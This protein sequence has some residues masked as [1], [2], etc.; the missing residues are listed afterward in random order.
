VARAF[1]AYEL[2]A[3]KKFTLEQIFASIKKETN[4][5]YKLIILLRA[6]LTLCAMNIGKMTFKHGHF[7]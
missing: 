7:L 4:K 2:G 5:G 6:I 3:P 1:E